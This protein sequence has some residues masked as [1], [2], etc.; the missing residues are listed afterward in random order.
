MFQWS[1]PGHHAAAQS[2]SGARTQRSVSTGNRNRGGAV[3]EAQ[4]SKAAATPRQR[5]NER[6]TVPDPAL[7]RKGRDPQLEKAI[8]VAMEELKKN[9]PPAMRRPAFPTHNRPAAP[10]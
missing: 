7:V 10:K 1:R 4:L 9:P 8:E 5:M 2:G 3:G 6:A